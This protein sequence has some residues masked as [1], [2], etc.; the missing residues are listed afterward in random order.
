ME[1]VSITVDMVRS[2]L[3][4]FCSNGEKVTTKQIAT[5]LGLKCEAEKARL[6]K[7][8]SDMA[9]HGELKRVGEGVFEYNFS[10]RPRNPQSFSKIWRFVRHAKPGWSI[11]E[12]S[13]MTHLSYTQVSRYCAWLEEEDFIC[14]VGRDGQASL[15]QATRKADSHPET[16]Y[17]PLRDTD[18]FAKEKSAAA[19]ITQ[20]LLCHDPYSKKVSQGVVE[21]CQ[22]L[23]A[24]FEKS[25]TQNENEQKEEGESHV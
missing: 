14:R 13:L 10:H 11:N 20:L 6:R 5:A 18:P 16:P 3:Q 7:R 19:R 8:L 23:L 24:R 4:S 2:A 17:P 1:G 21:A 22:V 9:H 25:V 15:Y 12:A